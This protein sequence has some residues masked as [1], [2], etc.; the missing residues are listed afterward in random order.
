MYIK[1]YICHLYI[2]KLKTAA[3]S[4]QATFWFEAF[5]E[6]TPHKDR[7]GNEFACG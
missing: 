4:H 5:R 6:I 1:L 2:I 3:F 7:K